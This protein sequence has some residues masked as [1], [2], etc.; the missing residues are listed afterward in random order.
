MFTNEIY[1]LT[2][3]GNFEFLIIS[4]NHIIIDG[5]NISWL[6]IFAL[7]MAYKIAFLLMYTLPSKICQTY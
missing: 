6:N 7:S 4:E 3:F 5:E 1:I 2:I